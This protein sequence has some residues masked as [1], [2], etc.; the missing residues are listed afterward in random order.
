M[1]AL[2]VMMVNV[3]I[4]FFPSGDLQVSYSPANA[5]TSRFFN[6]IR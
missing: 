6:R 5:N 4:F 1:F 3:L 2:H